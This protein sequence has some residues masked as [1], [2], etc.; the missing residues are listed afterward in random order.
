MKNNINN[1]ENTYFYIYI[2]YANLFRVT[3]V[4]EKLYSYILTEY[5]NSI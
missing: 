1:S 3:N 4:I 5:V 2:L